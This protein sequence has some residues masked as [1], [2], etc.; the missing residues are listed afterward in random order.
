MTVGYLWFLLNTQAPDEMDETG[1]ETRN[2]VDICKLRKQVWFWVAGAGIVTKELLAA[3]LA[4]N[5]GSGSLVSPDP[6]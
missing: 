5:N 1:V 4:Q 3:L 2:G 6:G